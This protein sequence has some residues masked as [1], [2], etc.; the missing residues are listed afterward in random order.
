MVHYH[1]SGPDARATVA[2][3]R[4]RGVEAASVRADLTRGAQVERVCQATLDAFGRVDVL[5]N[6]ASLF[7]RTP[8]PEVTEHDWD[9]ALNANLKSVFLCCQAF[10][11]MM[12]E[13]GGGC[14]VNLADVAGVRPWKNYLPYSIAKAGVIA[15][16]R[17]L[18][19]A[20]APQVRVN[21]IAPGI[22]LWP[23]DLSEA[24]RAKLLTKVPLG[25]AGTPEEVARTVQFLIE[26][27]YI[28]GAVVPVEGGRLLT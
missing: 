13:R 6:N 18:A 24:T 16:T 5:I 8:W 27:D 11:P 22:A 4:A 14:I 25:R 12:V 21:A 26:S 3:L 23:D 17:G 19:V 20:L 7:C 15:L 9:Q 2:E 28:T 10:A 1:R